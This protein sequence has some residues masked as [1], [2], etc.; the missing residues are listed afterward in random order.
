MEVIEYQ[1]TEVTLLVALLHTPLKV[2]ECI[3]ATQLVAHQ[4]SRLMA[5]EFTMVIPPMELLH[6]PSMG[7]VFIEHSIGLLPILRQS[8][9][10]YSQKS[11]ARAE[12]KK[13]E[14]ELMRH[15]W[16]ELSKKRHRD[17]SSLKI[18]IP[19][20]LRSIYEEIQNIG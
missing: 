18:I 6:T 9:I 5:T 14:D 4:L 13:N 16:S 15:T 20:Q 2:T 8:Q 3:V 12:R 11:A 1:F 7:F 19:N 10:E 17:I